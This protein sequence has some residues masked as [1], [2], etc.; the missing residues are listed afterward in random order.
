MWKCFAMLFFLYS[1]RFQI[2]ESYFEKNSENLCNW[3]ISI[4]SVD[5]PQN[6]WLF[7]KLMINCLLY[8]LDMIDLNWKLVRELQRQIDE[9]YLEDGLLQRWNIYSH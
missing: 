4:N 6:N 9:L 3:L 1:L 5:F 2:P 8:K 7:F